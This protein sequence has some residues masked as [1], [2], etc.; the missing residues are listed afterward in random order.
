MELQF[1]K[2]VN[3]LIEFEHDMLLAIS[4]KSAL[5]QMSATSFL[6]GIA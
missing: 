4:L 2:C 1:C 5:T 3:T 6:T